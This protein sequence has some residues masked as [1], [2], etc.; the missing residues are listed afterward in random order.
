MSFVSAAVKEPDLDDS[1]KESI[2]SDIKTIDCSLSFISDLL[3]NMLDMNRASSKQMRID[4]KA[5]DI[6]RDIFDPVRSV[7]FLRGAKVKVLIDCDKQLML[8]TDKL[9]LK[10]IILNLTMN[11]TKFVDTGFIRLRADLDDKKNVRMFVEDSGPGIPVEKRR[12]LFMKFQESLDLLNQGTGIGLCVCKELSELMGAD[13]YLDETYDSGVPN[14]PG[15]RFVLAMNAPPLDVEKTLETEDISSQGGQLRIHRK[16]EAL[17]QQETE[18]PD[19]LSILFV[20]DDMI[21]RKMFSR[22]LKR[23][24]PHCTVDEASNGETAIQMIEKTDYDVV[25]IDMYMASIEK[26]MLGTETVRAMRA[27]GCNSVLCG[28]SANDVEDEFLGAG[29]DAFMFKPFPCEKEAL[30][31]ELLRTLNSR[32]NNQTSRTAGGSN[33]SITKGAL[34]A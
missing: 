9:R 2:V 17:Q 14:F 31:A 1:K 20:D 10:Q 23:V 11:A 19:P 30:K 32:N 24:A 4:K 26:Q 13:I 6:F 28:L 5:T 25:Y 18:I 16:S 21:L 7:V 29:A 33:R 8:M 22:S 15:T 3:R 34:A 12:H 27:L